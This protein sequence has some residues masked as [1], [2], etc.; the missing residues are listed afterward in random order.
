MGRLKRVLT[1]ICSLWEMSRAEQK[2]WHVYGQVLRNGPYQMAPQVSLVLL[3]EMLREQWAQRSVSSQT[4]AL[5]FSLILVWYSSFSSCSTQQSSHQWV[6]VWCFKILFECR[7]VNTSYDYNVIYH[8][9]VLI[10]VI[11]ENSSIHNTTITITT[12]RNNI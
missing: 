7:Y 9:N 11:I 3:G 10:I 8:C 4:S 5:S 6:C 1:R 2:Q 12:Q